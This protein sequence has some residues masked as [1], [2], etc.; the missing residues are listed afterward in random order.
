MRSVESQGHHVLGVRP[1][2]LLLEQQCPLLSC[3][4]ASRVFGCFDAID[5]LERVLVEEDAIQ[6]FERLAELR[7]VL[8]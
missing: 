4:R 3:L 6:S 1:A 8:G 7:R 5:K 2:Q